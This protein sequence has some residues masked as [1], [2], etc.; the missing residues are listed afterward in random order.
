MKLVRFGSAGQES[1]RLVDGEGK[2]RDLCGILTD[3][4]EQA[5]SPAGL[6]R[7]RGIDPSN[8]PLVD[9]PVRFGPP[10]ACTRSKIP[11]GRLGRVE[12]TTALVCFLVSEECSYSTAATFD[13]SG[14][15][16]TF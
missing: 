14:G 12:E 2:V 11:K 4:D 16:T 9:E 8:L 15:R 6:E 1:P 3:I 7:L 5:I 13:T 10:V